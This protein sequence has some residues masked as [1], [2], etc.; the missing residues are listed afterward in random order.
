MELPQINRDRDALLVI[1]LQPDFM[2]GGA[3]AVAGGDEIVVPILDLLQHFGTVV[4]TQDWHPVGHI[5]FAEQHEGYKP[6]D[7]IELYGKKQTLWPRHCV[8]TSFG[9]T[10]PQR[11][12]SRADLIIRKGTD[13]KVDS[14]SAIRE[15]H[16]PGGS[17][18]STGLSGYLFERGIRRIFSCG[19]ARDVCVRWT[20][21]DIGL[22]IPQ[23]VLWDLTRSVNPEADAEVFFAMRRSGAEILS[24][25]KILT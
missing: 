19:L 8:Q 22:S 3:L 4:A 11:L 20:V 5:S 7:V 12:M 25:R 10:I 23:V 13:P 18:K 21:E 17:R 2:P 6:F 24:S 16:G 15:N 14:Y 1:D 9:A